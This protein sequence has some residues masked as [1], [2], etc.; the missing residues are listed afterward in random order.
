MTDETYVLKGDE[1]V[2]YTI[3]DHPKD[4]PDNFVVRAFI[5]AADGKQYASKECKLATTLEEARKFVP[6]DKVLTQR[7]ANDDP[8]IVETWI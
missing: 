1:L 2:L 5:L 3:Y 8:V 6:P 7:Y 4:Y